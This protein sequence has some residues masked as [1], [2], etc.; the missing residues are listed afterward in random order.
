MSPPTPWIG[1]RERIDIIA[2]LLWI[3]MLAAVLWA[4]QG[5]DA[6]GEREARHCPDW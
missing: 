5:Q 6:E 1:L 3:A 4:T 2:F